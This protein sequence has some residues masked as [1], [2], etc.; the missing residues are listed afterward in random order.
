M[1]KLTENM[2]ETKKKKEFPK[3]RPTS[4]LG[5]KFKDVLKVLPRCDSLARQRRLAGFDLFPVHLLWTRELSEDT[6]LI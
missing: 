1:S 5:E 6:F 2:K 3:L 4:F